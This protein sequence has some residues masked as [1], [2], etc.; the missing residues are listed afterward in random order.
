MPL[1]E[2]PD[3]PQAPGVPAVVRD[4]ADPVPPDNFDFAPAEV[5]DT[6]PVYAQWGILDANGNAVIEPDSFVSVAYRQNSRVANFPVEEGGFES[7]D[8]VQTPYD[9][10]VRVTK[11]Q[12]VE[13]RSAFLA[14]L[15]SLQQGLDVVSVVTPEV[16]LDA[17][18]LETFDY[19]RTAVNGVALLTVDLYF[20][21]IRFTATAEYSQVN[22]P[23]AP[24]AEPEVSNGQVQATPVA[25]SKIQAVDLPVLPQTGGASGSW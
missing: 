18:N 3:V 14:V 17:A 20:V 8:K 11:G 7:Y 4:G 24:S 21:Q 25:Q 22:S 13:A 16:V 2:Y 1:I 23:Q 19:D 6:P 9:L 15:E 12:S 10:R 5:P